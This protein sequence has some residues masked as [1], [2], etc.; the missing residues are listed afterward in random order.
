MQRHLPC[1]KIADRR[2]L[3]LLRCYYIASGKSDIAFRHLKTYRH[4]TNC[5]PAPFNAAA[6]LL[7]GSSLAQFSRHITGMLDLNAL[8]SA[9]G[10]CSCHIRRRHRRCTP[11]LSSSLIKR[12]HVHATCVRSRRTACNASHDS[13]PGSAGVEERDTDAAA[14]H[15]AASADA[16]LVDTLSLV[17]V[18][19]LWATYSPALRYLYMLPGPPTPATLTAS[20]AL[21]QAACLLPPV[22]LTAGVERA[23][24]A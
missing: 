13:K 10:L 23:L 20:R 1:C 22:L 5:S 9:G 18:S 7:L 2:K 11:F 17:A 3:R 21:L 4:L 6:H 14:G 19:G 15:D 16:T 8:L 12:H 24:Q